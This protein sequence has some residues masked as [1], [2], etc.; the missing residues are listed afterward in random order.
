MVADGTVNV[1]SCCQLVR[2]GECPNCAAT[3]TSWLETMKPMF[4][5]TD[6]VR[7]ADLCVAGRAKLS[8][9]YENEG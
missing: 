5:S 4:G 9:A 2:G 7:L 6:R 3:G 8:V 1:K